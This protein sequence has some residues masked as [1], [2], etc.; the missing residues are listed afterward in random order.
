MF[1]KLEIFNRGK[2]WSLVFEKIYSIWGWMCVVIGQ[3]RIVDVFFGR[4]GKE[5]FVKGGF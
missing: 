1:F 4:E 2:D 3:G 5:K